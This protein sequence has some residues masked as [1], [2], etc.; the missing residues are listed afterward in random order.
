MRV[1]EGMFPRTLRALVRGQGR[2]AVWLLPVGLFAVWGVWFVQARITVYEPSVQARLEVHRE[3]YAVDS[4]VEGRLVKTHVELHRKVSAGEVLFELAQEQEAR[5]LAEA[6]ALMKGQGPQ[7]E[8]ARAELEAEQSALQ[9]Q[10]ERGAASAEEAR[11]RL[12]EAEALARR[13]QEEKT[14]TE[15]LWARQLVSES[16]WHQVRTELE[17]AQAS[18]QAARAALARVKTDGT[19]QSTE[20]RVRIAALRGDIARLESA[21]NVARATVERLR[22]EV[23]RRV[24]RAPADGLLGETSSV[25]VGTQV[26]AG[27]RIA[28]VVAGGDVRIV[29]QFSPA[30]ALGR[31]RAGQQARMKLEGF[32]WTEFGLAR[33]TVVAVASEARD[34]LVRVE[35]SVDE[36]PPGVPMEHGL[37][38]TVDIAVEEATPLRLVLRALGRGL[39]GPARARP[40]PSRAPGT[41]E[42]SRGGR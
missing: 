5:Q 9:A 1:G 10:Q 39:G 29:G 35:L 6:E 27:D 19:M 8:A 16:E 41:L 7:L 13:A 42:L 25:R 40:L 37:Q 36:M 30:T 26:K 33:A 4:P 32:A 2:S 20:R 21:E 11:A 3:V 18:E 34:G 14:R 17:R 38:G 22:E 15:Q 28:T 24:V 23:E 12:S 31:V